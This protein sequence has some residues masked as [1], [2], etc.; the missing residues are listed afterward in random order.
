MQI[1]LLYLFVDV[2]GC[3]GEIGSPGPNLPLPGDDGDNG[4]T[5]P[6]GIKGQAGI[7]GLIGIPGILGNPG[8]KG[9]K[10]LNM[11]FYS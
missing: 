4:D 2:L 10:M 3:S 11:V 7:P 9:N 1:K 8:L 6:W 5:G